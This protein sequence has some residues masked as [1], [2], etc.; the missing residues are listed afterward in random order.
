MKEIKNMIH[1]DFHTMSGVYDFDEDFDAECFAANLYESGVEYINFPAQCNKGFCYF[2]TSVGIPYPTMKKDRLKSV[3]EACHKYGIGVSAYINFGICHEQSLRHLDWCTVD[4]N[5]RVYSGKEP[6]SYGMLSLCYNTEYRKYLMRLVKEIINNYDIDGLFC[7]CLTVTPCYC[8]NCMGQMFGK[9]VN[10]ENEREVLKFQFDIR[11]DVCSEIK[12]ILGDGK[13]L[14]FNGMPVINDYRTH[15]EL[16]WLPPS[17]GFEVFPIQ[18]ALGR[19]L[20]SRR[21]YMTGRFQ[22]DWGDFGGVKSL[23][24]MENDMFDA[25]MN[26]Y[27]I[28]FGDHLHP[29][30]NIEPK[31]I[32]R[33]KEVFLKK[34]S[35][36][37]LLKDTEYFVKVAVLMKKEYTTLPWGYDNLTGIARM[38]SELKI[39]FDI[40]Y[41]DESDFSKY[42]LLILADDYLISQTEKEKLNKFII[43]GGKI[44][45]SGFS[46][47][48][49]DKKEFV[50][51]GYGFINYLQKKISENGFYELVNGSDKMHNSTYSEGVSI[52]VNEGEVLAE[53]VK[54]YR[55]RKTDI[56]NGLYYGPPDKKTGE[57]AVVIN[58]NIAHVAFRI[59]TSYA[60]GFATEL[61]E[62]VRQ[63]IDKLIGTK[64]DARQLPS[65]ARCSLLNGKGYDLLCVKAT[66]PEIRNYK[67]II[68][69]HDVI[70]AGKKVI[71]D[72]EYSQA[73]TVDGKV[74]ELKRLNDKTEISLPEIFGF[75]LIKLVNV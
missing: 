2:N 25:V 73:V 52:T 64:I 13:N 69:E 3:I 11:L 75:E 43:G 26:G 65:W 30:R 67:G 5:N 49:V 57:I 53:Y 24:A 56:L 42:Q 41:P 37:P 27:D 28:C 47:L 72:G 16:E 12:H 36:E 22:N 6:F 20:F 1:F 58:K 31:F 60:N 4:R 66:H 10:V 71:L 40:L 29:A 14:F 74:C 63:I 23:A 17:W 35:Y 68:E 21:I 62:L 44:L 55:E 18:A 45:S 32:N 19:P 51:D 48:D 34:K 59:F 50:L 46:G 9:G 39:P 15:F 8:P 70:T 61:K 38:L 7:D 33:A 54:P